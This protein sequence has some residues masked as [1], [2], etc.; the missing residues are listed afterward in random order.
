V[1]LSSATTRLTWQ[2]YIHD[3][4]AGEIDTK[5]KVKDQMN[6]TKLRMVSVFL[7]A[8]GMLTPLQAW[9]GQSPDQL[10]ALEKKLLGDWVGLGP[11]DG[12]ITFRPDGTY[13]ERHVGVVSRDMIFLANTVAD[14][15]FPSVEWTRQWIRKVG[16]EKL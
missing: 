16:D 10:A 9:T 1:K 3:C 12:E 8:A 13:E 15:D 5:R 2:V 6:G 11:C 4:S 7:A 14:F